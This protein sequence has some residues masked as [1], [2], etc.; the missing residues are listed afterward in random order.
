MASLDNTREQMPKAPEHRAHQPS[1]V[2]SEVHK[3]PQ[4]P[5]DKGLRRP[6][7]GKAWL[8]LRVSLLAHNFGLKDMTTGNLSVSAASAPSVDIRTTALQFLR[9]AHDHGL[10][11]S[12]AYYPGTTLDSPSFGD[13]SV[14]SP[15]LGVLRARQIRFLTIDSVS[16]RISIFLRRASP[17]AKELKGLPTKCNGFSLNYHQGNPETVAAA[18]VAEATSTCA[19]HQVAGQNF[20]TCGSSISIGNNREAGTIGCLVR[21]E[22]GLIFGLS[23]NHV[24]G[25]CSYAPSG[26]P[27]I[28][29][30]ILDVSPTNP[31]PFTLG[32][33]ARQLPMHVGDPSSIDHTQN[34][35][36]ALFQIVNPGRVSSMQRGYYDTPSTIK[37]L[38][39]G[40]KVQKVGRSTG[41]KSGVVMGEIVGAAPVSY[42]AAQYGFS[43]AVYF[44]PLWVVHGVGDLFSDG[45]DSGSLVTHVDDAGVRHAVGIVVAGCADNSAP[46]GKRSIILPLRPILEQLKVQLVANHNI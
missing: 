1:I 5:E 31:H 26:L 32:I 24:S 42:A 18:N 14:G 12:D 36:A 25:A 2:T 40:M 15:S 3:M 38:V 29:P 13:E 22:T 37:D 19:I 43:G 8:Q 44:E 4:A 33:H 7:S 16:N 46:G 45:G 20:Y 23:N 34:S 21:D 17:T 35:D 10:L 9:W 39:A 30:G 28:A 27:V 11:A 41:L 6:T